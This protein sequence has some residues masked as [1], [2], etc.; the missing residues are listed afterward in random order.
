MTEE[1]RLVCQPGCSEEET[2]ESRILDELSVIRDNVGKACLKEL[3]A[4]NTPL[5][6]ALCGSKGSFINI[7]QMI[8]TF[9]QQ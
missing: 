4:T 5:T 7:S 8:G 1:G 2:L 3:H 9:K 6:M